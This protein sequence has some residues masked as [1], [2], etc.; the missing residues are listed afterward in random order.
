MP[1]K[2]LKRSS[3]AIPRGVLC[4][5]I[6][7]TVLHS[8]REGDLKWKG[9]LEGLVKCL[10]SRKRWYFAF[11]LTIPPDIVMSSVRTAICIRPIQRCTVS[12]LVR[13]GNR[14]LRRPALPTESFSIS[15]ETHDF[16]PG[17][18]LLGD[19]GR[20]PAKHMVLAVN[21]DDLRDGRSTTVRKRK[22]AVEGQCRGPAERG[23]ACVLLSRADVLGCNEGEST[24]FPASHP[25]PPFLRSRSFPS[26]SWGFPRSDP[27][28]TYV[29]HRVPRGD[30][31]QVLKRRI[32]TDPA[33]APPPFYLAERRGGSLLH[34]TC[35]PR[36][37]ESRG[38][39]EDGARFRPEASRN[40]PSS[41][42]YEGNDPKR[43]G[44]HR[45]IGH[46]R[47]YPV[48]DFDRGKN[49]ARVGSPLLSSPLSFE[50]G[51]RFNTEGGDK[52]Q[53]NRSRRIDD[54]DDEGRVGTTSTEGCGAN[55]VG[56]KDRETTP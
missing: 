38:G 28:R 44:R 14:S 4:G 18:Q 29:F 3:A 6:P 9:P 17:Q 46:L 27:A 39:K 43:G 37:I 42:V 41:Y 45:S 30:A 10:L 54:K 2:A 20:K 25:R 40:L 56:A 26:S 12:V 34:G 53:T 32:E 5:I 52:V 35:F 48:E 1:S 33:N 31:A 55:T 7:R 47:S 19:D 36:R 51:N 8:M 24:R 11:C 23:S 22:Q 49:D 16:L 13:R 50:P 21:D 15:H